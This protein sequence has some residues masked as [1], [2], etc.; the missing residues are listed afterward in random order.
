MRDE[1]G[2]FT[3]GNPGGPG[4]PSRE[5]EVSY[6]R[7]FSDVVDIDDWREIINVA[8][9]GAKKGDHRD[10]AWLSKHILGDAAVSADEL[11]GLLKDENFGRFFREIAQDESN[12]GADS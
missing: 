1:Q 4:R 9:S 6:L 3:K 11:D 2:R 10:R 12:P 5:L 8:V 7:A